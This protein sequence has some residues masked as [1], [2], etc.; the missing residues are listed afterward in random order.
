MDSGTIG[1]SKKSTYLEIIRAVGHAEFANY[2]AGVIGVDVALIDAGKWAS[3]PAGFNDQ[4]SNKLLV[5]NGPSGG[6]E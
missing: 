3:A 5:L 2:N 4:Y 1:L 6:V